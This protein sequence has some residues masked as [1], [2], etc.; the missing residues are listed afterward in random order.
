M[1]TTRMSPKMSEN[2]L[3]TMNSSPANVRPSRMVSRNELGSSQRGSRVGRPPVAPHFRR[4]IRDHEDVEEREHDNGD[5]GG[6]RHGPD[7]SPGADS[8]G[9]Q[10]RERTNVRERFQRGTSATAD[11]ARLPGRAYLREPDAE[12]EP[13]ADTTTAVIPYES[14]DPLTIGA[15]GDEDKVTRDTLSLEIPTATSSPRSIPTSRRPSAMRRRRP[16][17]RSSPRSSGPRFSRADRVGDEGRRDHRQPVPADAAVEAAAPGARRARGRREAGGDRV[18]ERQGLPDVRLGH[19]AEDRQG[20]PR[21]HGAARDRVPPE[22]P[23]QRR[24]LRVRRRV[25]A[26]H[27]GVAAQGGRGLRREDHDRPG[28]VEP[29]GRRRRR[30]AHPP[31]RRLGRDDRVEPLRVRALAADPLRR[32]RG[33]D[34]L[35]HRRGR[36]DVRP[37]R[38]DERRPRHAR[39]RGRVHLRLAPRRASQ[40]DRAL[41][42]DL[43]LRAPG[44]AGRH[45]DLRRVRPDRPP[46][47]P[48]GVGLHVRRLRRE[49]RR[50][51]HLLLALTGRLD[52]DRRL[53]R[54]RAHGPHEAV[55]AGDAGELPVGAQGHPRAGDPDVGRAASGC[56]STRS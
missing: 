28:A 1:F 35:G 49:G 56:R 39:P 22:R 48:H 12:E 33:A 41:Q 4:R 51:D 26:R 15:S 27:A 44:N 31:G 5:R 45:R 18:R 3:A 40:G 13:M 38:D 52:R 55:H 25:V 8:L 10:Q 50:L 32:V 21:A 37:L 29:L 14:L 54:F 19:R 11:P 7:D 53:S 9:H 36:D 46:V 16:A 2:P 34:A 23:A 24:Q 43:R 30:E 20:Q 42:R 17:P 6:A 47:L